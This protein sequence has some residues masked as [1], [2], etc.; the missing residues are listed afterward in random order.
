MKNLLL[1][2]AVLLVAVW[3]TARILPVEPQEQRPGLSLGGTF[4]ADQATRW[5]FLDGRNQILVQMNT[6]YGIPHSVTTTSWV[7][8][9]VL[10]VPCARCASK[11]W[12][13]HVARDNHVV[14]KVGGEL[15]RRQ[16]I[17][18]EDHAEMMSVMGMPAG[19]GHPEGV[20]VYR[21]IN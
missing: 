19:Q 14:L 5:D 12:P 16:A 7:R 15:Y 10:Y 1:I 3:F 11:Q 2:F 8:D 17:K 13:K 20:W 4:A 6:W 21:M 18:I 9:G